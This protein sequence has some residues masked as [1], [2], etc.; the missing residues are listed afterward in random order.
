MFIKFRL[1]KHIDGMNEAE[2]VDIVTNLLVL[3]FRSYIRLA[4]ALRQGFRTWR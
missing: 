2:F 1:C 3:R 4:K